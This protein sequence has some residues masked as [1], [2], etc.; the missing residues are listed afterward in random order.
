MK[1]IRF[2]FALTIC[3]GLFSCNKQEKVVDVVI[4][5]SSEC[6]HCSHLISQMDSAKLQYEF[7]DVLGNDHNRDL[8]FKLAS[9]SGIED[10]FSYPLVSVNDVVVAGPKFEDVY[11]IIEQ[12]KKYG[13]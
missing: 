12:E 13:K 1:L 4:F 6:G 5:G 9:L 7:L 2:F 8:M 3:I 11:R 10:R